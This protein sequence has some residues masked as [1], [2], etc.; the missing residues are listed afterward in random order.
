MQYMN[1]LVVGQI[2]SACMRRKSRYSWLMR[3]QAV[4]L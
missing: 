3:D 1:L 4:L 2:G